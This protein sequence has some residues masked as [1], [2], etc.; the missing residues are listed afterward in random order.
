VPA[1]IAQPGSDAHGLERIETD[2]AP[3]PFA[4]LELDPRIERGL[5]DRRYVETTPIQSVTIPAVLDGIDVIGCAETGTGKTAA[6]LLPLMQRLLAAGN[7]ERTSTRVLVLAPTRELAVQ[8]ED[9][10][11]GLAYHTDLS[12]AAVYGGVPSGPQE[13]ALL[14][15]VD[16]VVATPGRLL[17]HLGAGSA[18]FAGVEVLVLDEADRL[19][20]M[21][22][23]PD[24][25]RI[26]AALPAARQT[27]FFSATMSDDV[28]RSAKEIMRAP[29]LI[30]VGQTTMP[31]TIT[32]VGADVPSTE[33]AGW[34]ARFLRQTREPSIVF[35]RTK[36]GADRLAS[37]LASAG[38]RCAALHADRTQS[39]RTSAVEGFKS[40][41]YLALVATDIAARGLDIDGVGHVIN[42]EVP[43][44]AEMYVHRVGRTGRARATGTALTLI[45]SDEV[46]TLQALERSLDLSLARTGS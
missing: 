4:S 27:L 29:K 22:F 16:V 19:L 31:D 32:H 8:I 25:R 45:D 42:Y 21:G 17:D 15:S 14:A 11:Q 10:F 1:P 41:R 24:V 43:S 13:R 6:F 26:V 34:L 5:T 46:R 33:K 30:H 39:E 37:R 12:V 20:D 40:G 36:R 44:S 9:E 7:A 3:V 35:V 2:P 18:R 23:W 38:I 28:F